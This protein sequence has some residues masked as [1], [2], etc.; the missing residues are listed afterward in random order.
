MQYALG[1]T[2]DEA[3]IYV[4]RR[5]DLASFRPLSS[6]AKGMWPDGTVIDDVERVVRRRLDNVLADDLRS[7]SDQ[8]LFLKIDTQGSEREVIAGAG[9]Y[10]TQF[11]GIQVEASVKPIYEGMTSYL[12]TLS[13]LGAHG[14]ELTGIF[15]VAR[16]EDLRIIELDCVMMRSVP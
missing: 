2:E 7:W 12:E 14:F 1:E 13:L 3:P 10:L 8:G 9:E 4:S 5:S 16:D 6:Y 15:P 11:R